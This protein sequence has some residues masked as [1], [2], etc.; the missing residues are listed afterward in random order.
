[1]RQVWTPDLRLP[2]QYQT[3]TK[4]HCLVRDAQ[5]CELAQGCYPAEAR[6]GVE[7]KTVKSQVRR[8]NHYTPQ[9]VRQDK[10]PVYAS[11]E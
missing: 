4:L 3:A 7:P 10:Q 1:M 2:S 8:P 6:P 11:P 5:M 9:A